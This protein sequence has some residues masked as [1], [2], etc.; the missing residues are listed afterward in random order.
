[1][2]VERIHADPRVRADYGKVAIQRGP[3]VY[4][5]EQVDNGPD[6]YSVSL[7]VSAELKTVDRPGLLGGVVAIS[8]RG[9]ARRVSPSAG[10]LYEGGSR[11]D[12]V[13]ERQLLFIPYYAWAN[14][15]AGQM[16][17]WVRE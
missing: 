1:M 8:G 6:L 12:G 9:K 15:A 3:V 14:R 7:P 17:L 16:I 11:M 4:C 13:E 10:P 5:L 2:S